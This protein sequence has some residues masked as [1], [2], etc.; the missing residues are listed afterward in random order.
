MVEMK[1]QY[2]ENDIEKLIEETTKH[3]AIYCDMYFDAHGEN[4]KDVQAGLVEFITRLTAEKGVIYCKGQVLEAFSRP[5]NGTTIYSTS[6]NVK[7]LCDNFNKLHD[8][9]LRYSPVGLDIVMPRTIKLTLEEAHSLLLDAS[10]STTEYSRLI[11]QRISK[12]EDLTKSEE[13]FR[14]RAEIGKKLI[15][16]GKLKQAVGVKKE[17]NK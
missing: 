13:S 1:K 5:V 17:H 12:P 2:S 4:E 16:S 6:A 10:T 11:L 7:L 8:L 9:C 15:E 14:R 3:G